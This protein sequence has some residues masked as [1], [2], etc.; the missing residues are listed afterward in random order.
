MYVVGE[1]VPMGVVDKC[2]L[3]LLKGSQVE[4]E[5]AHDS[6]ESTPSFTDFDTLSVIHKRLTFWK[7]FNVDVLEADPFHHF[8]FSITAPNLCIQSLS[9][10]WTALHNI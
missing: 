9:V 6:E 10:V 3:A 5:C 1:Q 4:I 8:S 2:V 7:F